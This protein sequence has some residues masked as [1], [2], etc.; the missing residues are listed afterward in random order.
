MRLISFLLSFSRAT[1]LSAIVAGVVSGLCNTGLLAVMNRALHGGPAARGKL[2]VVF[3]GLCIVVPATRIVSELL[4]LHLGQQSIYDLRMRMCR[5]ILSVPLL[6]LERIGS[7]RLHS[8]LTGDI[9]TIA[10]AVGLM[11]V[12][13]INVSIF[14]GCL[15]YLGFLS[16]KVLLGVLV[17][18]VAGIAGYQL[19]VARAMAH[20][21]QS[22]LVRDTLYAGFR[23]LTEGSKELKLHYRRRESFVNQS[24]HDAAMGHRRLLI[25]GQTLYT[26]ASSWGQLLAFAVIGLV[27]FGVPLYAPGL[28]SAETLTG[29]SLA[30]LFVTAP[31]QLVMNLVPNLGQADAAL[32]R[33]EE[34]GL[35]LTRHAAG[36]QTAVPPAEG[37]TWTSLDLV[38]VSH[39]YQRQGEDRDFV[40]GPIDLRL[41]PGELVFLVGGNGSGKT[42]LAKVLV[43][44]YPPESGHIRFNGEAVADANREQYRQHFSV[45]FA[46]FFL[47]ERLLGLESHEI[48]ERALHYLT[49]LQIAHKVKVDRGTLS[50]TDLSQ[51]Q[52]KRL[53]LLTAYLEDRPIYVFDEWAADQDPY[54]KDVFY[55]HLLPE[56]K[57]R[58]KTIVVISHDDRYYHLGDRVLKLEDGR[59]SQAPPP[60]ALA[61]G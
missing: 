54:F 27:I 9:L 22:I 36:E 13:F 57:R 44:L 3:I 12:L 49:E 39:A 10:G 24:L 46:D 59:L 7:A 48:D 55:L 58:G 11:P 21:R 35:D 1:V 40:L 28:A 6:H 60:A 37:G 17:F 31:L 16:W 32:R 19:P 41:E 34:M 51:G 56:L 5:R 20:F 18:I 50:T 61:V 23:A 8:I 38:G 14:A 29:F 15:V 2:A 25:Q 33:V 43:G 42:T 4:L 52:R 26:V 30:L 45:V 47:F 53:A